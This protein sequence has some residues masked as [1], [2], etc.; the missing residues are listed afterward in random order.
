MAFKEY[1][2]TFSSTI[3]KKGTS[4]KAN[5]DYTTAHNKDE[6]GAI[7]NNDV[8][9]T[10]YFFNTLATDGRTTKADILKAASYGNVSKIEI[11]HKATDSRNSNNVRF[12]C[13]LKESSSTGT[14]KIT[15][16]TVQLLYDLGKSPV[17]EKTYDITALGVRDVWA[18]S[19]GS[20]YP[21][22]GVNL[23]G[24]LQYTDICELIITANIGVPS[25][26]FI[27]GAWR[28]TINSK[29]FIDGVWKDVVSGKIFIDGAWH[30]II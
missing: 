20:N 4:R 21:V 23:W 6:I 2:F 7:A 14:T 22:G 12:L 13:G 28:E 17:K 25:K 26:I 11:R 1:T 29:V 19:L 15:G 27:D 16:E 5:L 10:S 9:C 24:C 3:H 30:D 18:Y 8:Y